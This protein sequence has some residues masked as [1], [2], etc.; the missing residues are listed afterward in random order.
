MGGNR[1]RQTPCYGIKLKRNENVMREEQAYLIDSDLA[2][3]VLSKPQVPVGSRIY[4]SDA[5][6]NYTNKL[7]YKHKKEIEEKSKIIVNFSQRLAKEKSDILGYLR[8]KADSVPKVWGYIKE[9]E[10]QS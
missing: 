3:L 4:V 1:H 2:D 10:F 7:T 5:L 9:L 6:F 8:S